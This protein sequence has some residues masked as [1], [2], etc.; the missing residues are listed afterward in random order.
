METSHYE[1]W[2]HMFQAPLMF[3]AGV[4]ALQRA[5]KVQSVITRGRNSYSSLIGVRDRFTVVLV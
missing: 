4:R 1:G 5:V 3:V 2:S